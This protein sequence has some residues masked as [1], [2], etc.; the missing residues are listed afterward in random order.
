MRGEKDRLQLLNLWMFFRQRWFWGR[1]AAEKLIG[2]SK[3]CQG[4]TSVVP[5]PSQNQF[6]FYRLR[7]NSFGR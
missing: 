2:R 6:G 7:K 5:Q 1:E 4:T 3:K